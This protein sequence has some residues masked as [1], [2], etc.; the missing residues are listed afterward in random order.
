MEDDSEAML[1]SSSSRIACA[2]R[3]KVKVVECTLEDDISSISL[4][5]E[6]RRVFFN[7]SV[8]T[9][10]SFHVIAPASQSESEPPEPISL[11]LRD[12]RGK[13]RRS[14]KIY[15]TEL[16]SP[17]GWV[18]PPSEGQGSNQE[19]QISNEEAGEC[20][21]IIALASILNDPVR[22][23][24]TKAPHT[25]ELCKYRSLSKTSSDSTKKSFG[26]C[27]RARYSVRPIRIHGPE[28]SSWVIPTV[29]HVDAPRSMWFWAVNRP[30]ELDG[31]EGEY[32]DVGDGVMA[33]KRNI[34]KLQ[35]AF[36]T[37]KEKLR[38]PAQ[39]GKMSILQAC[40]LAPVE[41]A[42]PLTISLGK[43]ILLRKS[44][45]VETSSVLG[46]DVKYIEDVEISDT[47]SDGA[48]EDDET[49]VNFEN[50]ENFNAS[51]DADESLIDD[52]FSEDEFDEPPSMGKLISVRAKLQKI[53]QFEN[54][55][56]E[57]PANIED[58]GA[59]LHKLPSL[60][61]K[62]Q[63]MLTLEAPSN[64]SKK[65]G[66]SQPTTDSLSDSG[67]LNLSDTAETSF[68]Y[69]PL[70]K[71][72]DDAEQEMISVRRELVCA[73]AERDRLV[74]QMHQISLIPRCVSLEAEIST[75]RQSN[76]SLKQENLALLR[77]IKE[78]ESKRDAREINLMTRIHDMER[79]EEEKMIQ[80]ITRVKELECKEEGRQAKLI[81]RI[82]ELECKEKERMLKE[83]ER[84]QEIERQEKERELKEQEDRKSREA[85]ER[86][87]MEDAAEKATTE[88]V[89]REVVENGKKAIAGDDI[90]AGDRMSNKEYNRL[91]S[92]ISDLREEL[93]RQPACDQVLEELMAAKQELVIQK[94]EKE[95]MARELAQMKGSAAS[96]IRVARSPA[97]KSPKNEFL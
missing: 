11:S 58:R 61:A 68:S 47:E 13:Q 28:T 84:V 74:E 52:A 93:D 81:E 82:Q 80:L 1:H 27:S 29:T 34:E 83:Q 2:L 63:K 9:E 60:R 78:L 50:D 32:I 51:L 22:D 39:R 62:M 97:F 14:M 79:R 69:A 90:E 3:I 30:I 33:P 46:Q 92:V 48:D 70:M 26:D 35:M 21:R 64:D 4:H 57:R 66:S 89:K 18:L 86:K 43:P 56:L 77:K 75:I 65:A 23:L 85:A 5:R 96:P 10:A 76:D 72:V 12:K 7:A 40:F 20:L 37:E 36:G 94:I 45:V 73:H 15:L 42:L 54:P 17:K 95:N 88:A 53:M 38:I 16:L 31:D 87:A 59:P 19:G 91:L 24:P 41:S 25:L 49:E 8:G 71:R 44:P 6:S 55:N 67:A